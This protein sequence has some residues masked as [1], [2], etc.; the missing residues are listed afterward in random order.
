MSKKSNGAPPNLLP[1]P[2]FDADLLPDALRPWVRDI[3]ERMQCP[4]DFPAVGAMLA[5]AGVVGRQVAIRP[6]RRDDWAVTA[7]LWGGMVARPGFLKTPALREVMRPLKRLEARAAKEHA[8]AVR[9][10]QT[11]ALVGAARKKLA[12]AEIEK[13]IKRGGDDP[14]R[15]AAD[16]VD[17]T[18]A[19]P[20]RRR[21]VVNDPTVE[22]LGAILNENPN[23]VLLERDELTGF[24][25][26]LDKPG[27]EDARAFY[28]ECWAG[29]GRFTVDRIGRGTLDILACCV[30]IVGTVQPGPLQS[31]IFQMLAGGA[32]DDGLLPRFQLLVWPD[33]SP[34]WHNVDRWPDK[35]AKQRVYEVFEELANL[36]PFTVGAKQEGDEGGK[37][38]V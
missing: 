36:D 1:V 12:Q 30:S 10:Y 23:G 15:M 18:E 5:L 34:T 21:Y 6:K 35:T 16:L 17:E 2:V 27:R 9:A 33:P 28:L 11:T 32:G 26:A 13:A 25:R 20:T 4:I 3:T 31:Y 19:E 29:D 22:K 7:N 24:L 38:V 14:Q 8:D 37:S